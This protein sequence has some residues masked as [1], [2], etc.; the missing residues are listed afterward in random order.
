MLLVFS[1]VLLSENKFI[2]TQLFILNLFVKVKVK[3]I[4]LVLG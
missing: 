4:Y 1:L 3:H 2:F